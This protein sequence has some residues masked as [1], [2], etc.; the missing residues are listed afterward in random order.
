MKLEC[1]IAG[2]F[3]G[4]DLD[5][6][7]DLAIPLCFN[8]VQP[9]HFEA[10]H[11]SAQTFESGTFVGDTRQGGGCNVAEYRLIPH[12][13]GTHTECVGHISNQRIS[14]HRILP[15]PFIPATLI[16]VTPVPASACSDSYLPPKQE[17]D[18]LITRGQLSSHLSNLSSDFLHGLIIRTLSNDRS[19]M[20]RRYGQ[21]MPAFFSLEAMA[22][23]S[24]LG[25]Q[26]LLVDLPSVDRMFDEG[27]LSAHH[28]FWNVPQGS[29]DVDE[30]HHSLKTI[31]EMIYVDETVPDGHYLLNLQTPSFVADAAP[32]RPVI[33]PIVAL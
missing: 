11:A 16:T 4:V 19:K 28:H 26:H 23:I 15:N 1:H 24:S 7:I 3:Y 31:T 27:R 2:R 18:V 6:P 21:L 10:P 13:N 8:G 25:I 29:H 32:S 12:C 5:K 33:Y 17:E 30:N 9:N 22:V 20:S 14:L